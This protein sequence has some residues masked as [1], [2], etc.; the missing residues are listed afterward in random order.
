[1]R[2]LEAFVI[3]MLLVFS[4][5]GTFYPVKGEQQ[6]T[7]DNPCYITQCTMITQSGYYKLANDIVVNDVSQLIPVNFD[8][9]GNN[10]GLSCIAIYSEG[11]I[12]DGNGRAVTLKIPMEERPPLALS[13]VYV[14]GFETFAMEEEIRN[15]VI[16]GWDV[17]VDTGVSGLRYTV[18]DIMNP[19]LEVVYSNHYVTFGI[20]PGKKTNF[21]LYNNTIRNTIVGIAIAGPV[22]SDPGIVEGDFFGYLR[23]ALPTFSGLVE[24]TFED[25][26]ISVHIYGVTAGGNVTVPFL[27]ANNTVRRSYLGIYILTSVPAVREVGYFDKLPMAVGPTLVN[28]EIV[29]NTQ[30]VTIVASKRV[31]FINNSVRNNRFGVVVLGEMNISR[32]ILEAREHEGILGCDM[33]CLSDY[34]IGITS[35]V[36]ISGNEITNNTW[37]IAISTAENL[38]ISGNL[39]ADNRDTYEEV[40]YTLPNG[41]EVEAYAIPSFPLHGIGLYLHNV[42]NS[43]IENNELFGNGIGP[44]TLEYFPFCESC[45][46]IADMARNHAPLGYIG[47]LIDIEGENNTIRE[48]YIH[49]NAGIGIYL[50]SRDELEKNVLVNDYISTIGTDG[51]FTDF[52]VKETTVNGRPVLM[53]KN[54]KDV[55]INNAGQVFV[56]NSS[57]VRIEGLEFQN[58]R[59]TPVIV[60]GSSDVEIMGI[61]AKELESIAGIY[62]QDSSGVRITE[63]SFNGN[64]Y[65]SIGVKGSKDVLIEGNR[66]SENFGIPVLAS[67]VEGLDISN[68]EMSSSG[69]GIVA[70]N[71]ENG[72]IT[73]NEIS[74]AVMRKRLLGWSGEYYYDPV[75]GYYFYAV[76]VFERPYPWLPGINVGYSPIATIAVN[77]TG[78]EITSNEILENEL[79]GIHVW[80]GKNVKITSNRVENNSRGGVIL[81]LPVRTGKNIRVE[82]VIV[83]G[84]TFVNNGL[85][86]TGD[87]GSTFIDRLLIPEV[88][89]VRNIRV[90]DNTVNGRPLVYLENEEGVEIS[91]A[92]QVIAVN[93]TF[94]VKGLDVAFTD[95]PLLAIDSRVTIED[96]SFQGRWGVAILRSNASIKNTRVEHGAEWV[97]Y[98]YQDPVSEK[99]VNESTPLLSFGFHLVYSNATLLDVDVVSKVESNS[100]MTGIDVYAEPTRLYSP[101]SVKIS[102]AKVENELTGIDVT[103]QDVEVLYSEV[104]NSNTAINVKAYGKATIKGNW[105]SN[106]TWGLCISPSKHEK[107]IIAENIIHNVEEAGINIGGKDDLSS[108]NVTGNEVR[109]SKYGL[110][111][112]VPYQGM[113]DGV[114]SNNLFA[115]NYYGLTLGARS[116]ENV[117]LHTNWLVNNTYGLTINAEK[118]EEV[119]VYNNYFDNYR[120]VYMSHTLGGVSFNTT[121][122]PGRNIVGGPLIGGNYWER[123]HGTDENFDGIGDEPYQIAYGTYDYLPLIKFK[124]EP[125]GGEFPIIINEPGYYRL[126]TDGENLSMEYAVLI[127]ASNVL[128]DG[129]NHTLSG[130]ELALYG[131]KVESVENVTVVNLNLKGWLLAGI[132]AENTAKI[133][134]SGNTVT[135][136]TAEG[137]DVR[138]SRGAEVSYN[139]IKDLTGDGV[140]L[141]DT[142]NSSISH[143]TLENAKGSGVELD[144]GSAGNLVWGN[145]ISS[146]GVGIYLRPG[147]RSNVI[148]SNLVINNSLGVYVS[149]SKFNLIYNNYFDN[150]RNV[151]VLGNVTNHWN[152]T[153]REGKN[154][155]G[156][157]LL[158]GNY[159]SELKDCEDKNLDGFCDVPYVIDD[160]NV[161]YLP[162]TVSSD[163]KPPE[164]EIISPE[165]TTYYQNV[166]EIKVRASDDH[167]VEKVMALV[168]GSTWITLEFDGEYYTAKIT[169][170]EGHHAIE[171]YAYDAAGNVNSTGVEFTVVVKTASS[172]QGTAQVSFVALTYIYYQWYHRTLEEFNVLYN[173]SAQNLDN[174]TL[175]RIK[176]L[177]VLAKK[178]Y[179]W[180]E[181]HCPNLTA[182][183]VRAFIHMRKAYIYI[184]KALELLGAP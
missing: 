107:V 81:G 79:A 135:G 178:E 42:S 89:L 33:D 181:E 49:D 23:D 14:E 52:E 126:E 63:S 101:V 30:G 32:I 150:A 40:P 7:P 116:I 75:F 172:W 20:L 9:E 102:G 69:G 55:L 138:N 80:N 84:N 73:K 136:N 82:K 145:S 174:E 141:K 45:E 64:Y 115:E 142:V 35:N 106:A 11:V 118:S 103:A 88:P 65:A 39:I 100:S 117:E 94:T 159:W 149:N 155:L 120:D 147:S 83:R 44:L 154:I 129:G 26:V 18:E 125:I 104:K 22:V 36:T 168:D 1:M 38:T 162:L 176:D 98:S 53:V 15:L 164:V 163:T 60:S 56:V 34:W 29:N 153:K 50:R 127:N 108:F 28:N 85:S 72:R 57:N 110:L 171:V 119:T 78:M 179:L 58:S 182:A 43:L 177:L 170:G 70:L 128:L 169:L 46:Y 76:P 68:N 167:V 140:Y 139:T 183:D 31:G 66:F 112:T 25:N 133:R 184:K 130:K 61:N 17:G 16:D 4:I 95:L 156:G 10:A 93:S 97:Y 74:D 77:G 96:S 3:G 47:A 67:G 134:I 160:N 37:G 91:N 151:K 114:I 19:S 24:N 41:K 87:Y 131:V 13:A 124:P 175:A 180:V 121:V 27:I 113:G 71:I 86:I 165:N 148:F 132:Y 2:R 90:E 158:G 146:S 143:N 123:Y 92:G 5:M 109:N 111:V 152:V 21:L 166:T 59:A 161:D 62:V 122:R 48:N 99:I 137:V 8:N 12:I 6:C 54:A 144:T 173:S 157:N 105:I 51:Y